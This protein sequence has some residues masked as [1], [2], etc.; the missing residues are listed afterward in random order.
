MNKNEIDILLRKYYDG[1]TTPEEVRM[2]L[3]ALDDHGIDALLLRGLNQ[4]REEVP[5]VPS[6]LEQSLSDSIDSWQKEEKRE[7][8]IPATWLRRITWAAVAASVALIATLGWWHLRGESQLEPQGPV[9]A[10]NYSGESKPELTTGDEEIV[11]AVDETNEE[12]RPQVAPKARPVKSVRRHQAV[13]IA[14]AKVEADDDPE[15]SE[16]DEEKVLMALVTF[17]TVLNKGV[18]QLEEA[19]ETIEEVNN[20]IKQHLTIN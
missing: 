4:L 7:K 1:E 11:V 17:S 5:M 13:H 18:G 16:A 6:G 3:E 15:I 2:L 12:V 8:V 20:T 10:N 14:Q 9:I 19:S